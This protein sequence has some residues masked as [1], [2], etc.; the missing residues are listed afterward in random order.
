MLFVDVFFCLFCRSKES[1][2]VLYQRPG[3]YTPTSHN[4]IGQVSIGKC[5]EASFDITQIQ[6]TS[7]WCNIMLLGEDG[8]RKLS[9]WLY[10]GTTKIHVVTN[11]CVATK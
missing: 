3:D 6:P 8:A 10:P 4:K 1:R 2:K 9:I 7:P 5:F 11:V